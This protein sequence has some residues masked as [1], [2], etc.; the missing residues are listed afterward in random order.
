[1]TLNIP[2]FF[3]LVIYIFAFLQN[4]RKSCLG[5]MDSS[6]IYLKVVSTYLLVGSSHAHLNMYQHIC[7]LT[8]KVMFEQGV[9]E[10]GDKTKRPCAKN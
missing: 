6:F 4:G 8:Y 1:M 5:I 7:K 9:K 3:V 2:T 10:P